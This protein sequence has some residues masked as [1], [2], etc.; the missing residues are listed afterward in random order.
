MIYNADGQ[1]QGGSIEALVKHLTS[2]NATPDALFSSSFFL[3]F[4][5]FTTPIALAQALAHRFSSLPPDEPNLLA[6]Q[7]RTCNAFKG[8]MESHWQRETDNEAL[9]IIIDFV[10]GPLKIH[11]PFAFRRL[12][13]LTQQVVDI[14]HPL[15]PRSMSKLG[16][17]TSLGI[18]L[19]DSSSVPTPIVNKA[20]LATLAKYAREGS[21]DPSILDFDPLELARQITIK[22]SSQ[23]CQIIPEELLGQEFSKK[24]GKSVAV[25]VKAMSSLSTDLAN[26]IG[27]TILANEVPLKFRMNVIRHW[28]RVAEKCLELKNYNCLMA[29][30][31]ALQSSVIMRLKKTWELLPPRYHALFAE[32]KSIIVYEKNY[33]SYRTLLRNQ[34]VPCI[35]Y[36]GVYLTDL[37]FADEGN[38][39]FRVFHPNT[40]DASPV[41]NFDKHMRTTKIIAD[42]QRFQVPYRFQGVPEIQDWLDIEIRR[43]HEMYQKDQHMLY[44]RSCYVEPRTGASSGKFMGIVGDTTIKEGVSWN[45]EIKT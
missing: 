5:L 36:L 21:P 45:E 25:N 11:L 29:V 31:C 3:T 4:R 30:T 40:E 2:S 26:Y 28:I 16:I 42:L 1:V 9:P 18:L 41:I 7:L 14:N 8:W 32:L 37:T 10:N 33:A 19:P 6:A 17:N 24:S 23:F 12:I 38:P 15:V 20:H 22:E 34:T 35:P 43:V 27:E 13:E 39:D 44:R